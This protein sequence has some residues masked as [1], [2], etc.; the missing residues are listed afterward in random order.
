MTDWL[1]RNDKCVAVHNKYPKIPPSKSVHFAT[2]ALALEFRSALN[3]TVG[4]RTCNVNLANLSFLC[5][6][7]VI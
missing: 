3:L 1:D 7:F 5:K 2:L 6:K 4:F